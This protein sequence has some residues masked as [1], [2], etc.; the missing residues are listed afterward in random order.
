[1]TLTDKQLA[2]FGAE[3]LAPG[4]DTILSKFNRVVTENDFGPKFLGF[5]KSF[6]YGQ[7]T[8]NFYKLFIEAPILMH[9]AEMELEEKKYKVCSTSDDSGH[10]YW[11]G[12][13]KSDPYI[14]VWIER[15]NKFRAFWTA[16]Y[17]AVKGGSDDTNKGG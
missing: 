5:Y 13:I 15:E 12:N 11:I 6:Q 9:L 10:R 3:F 4:N 2:E 16:V 14:E 1:M 7:E 17:M 8:C